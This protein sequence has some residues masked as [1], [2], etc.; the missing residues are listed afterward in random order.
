MAYSECLSVWC[1]HCCYYHSAQ[2]PQQ[3]N[4][5][6]PGP[7]SFPCAPQPGPDPPCSPFNICVTQNGILTQP[8]PGPRAQSRA[9]FTSLIRRLQGERSQ[10]L[11]NLTKG[12]TED[13]K[14]NSDQQVIPS[15]A[16]LLWLRRCPPA[17]SG[18]RTACFTGD[19]GQGDSRAASSSTECV[20][21]D[22]S[23]QPRVSA[24]RAEWC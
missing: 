24:G 2:S 6:G 8:H 20:P 11:E 22:P 1:H 10:L 16:H 19:V 23:A 21:G 12:G 18:I 14:G 3:P 9:W 5:V 13:G 17:R 4:P 7:V 15:L